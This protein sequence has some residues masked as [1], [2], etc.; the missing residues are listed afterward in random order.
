APVGGGAGAGGGR[1][2]DSALELRVKAVLGDDLRIEPELERWFPIW[3][4]PGL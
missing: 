2:R 3:G 4:A 1:R